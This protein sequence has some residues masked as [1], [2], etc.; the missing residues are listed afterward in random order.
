[1]SVHRAARP[2]QLSGVRKTN[3]SAV[4]VQSSAHIVCDR[5][6]ARQAAISVVAPAALT[7]SELERLAELT[8]YGDSDLTRLLKDIHAGATEGVL[9]S[10]AKL[11]GIIVGWAAVDVW[12][13]YLPLMN[14]YVHEDYRERGIGTVLVR[15]LIPVY[16]ETYAH[17]PYVDAK[18]RRFYTRAVPELFELPEAKRVT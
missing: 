9:I 7:L 6:R 16:K 10:V 3:A 8:I 4:G 18:A 1:M 17:Q 11:G 15:A 5:A 14:C 2:I 13:R 12:R